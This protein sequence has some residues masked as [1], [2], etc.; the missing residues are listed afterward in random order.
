MWPFNP[1]ETAIVCLVFV[2]IIAV[3]AFVIYLL[4]FTGDR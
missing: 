2:P 4:I 1:V 3:G